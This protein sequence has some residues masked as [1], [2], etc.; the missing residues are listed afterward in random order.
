MPATSQGAAGREQLIPGAM[1]RFG[2]GGGGGP[3]QAAAAQAVEP[4]EEMV[5][6]LMVG[7]WVD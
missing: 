6:T 7:G 1:P 3:A 2:G 5:Q 4:S